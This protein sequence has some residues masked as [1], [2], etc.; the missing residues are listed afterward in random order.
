MWLT[1][2]TLVRAAPVDMELERLKAAASA[3]DARLVVRTSTYDR[4]A[5]E[6]DQTEFRIDTGARQYTMRYKT[7]RDD[8]ARQNAK[9]LNDGSSGYGMVAP[10]QNWYHNGFVQVDLSGPAGSSIRFMEGKP[11][12]LVAAGPRVAYDLVF[13]D[14][15]ATVV[16]RTV[17]LGGRDELFLSVAGRCAI[18]GEG[19]LTTTFCGYPL[20]FAPP[21]D[22]WVHADGQDIRHAD[23]ER[24]QSP[25]D[26]KAAPWLLLAD[27]RLDPSGSKQGLLG[28]A[29]DK[30]VLTHAAVVH[31]RNY[32]ILPSF[33]GS[34]T[35]EQR[36][37]VYTFGPLTWEA[38]RAGLSQ[39]GYPTDLVER[40]FG[41][42]P[43][44]FGE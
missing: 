29:Y 3:A 38:A 22:R 10:H 27:H 13:T 34:A 42:L 33:T 32:A 20:G 36:Y 43:P 7:F 40:A 28:L 25:L 11:R 2:A 4:G 41:G 15:T 6:V 31:N 8:E 26:L 37:I 39:T 12:P 44:P 35:E 23:K 17:A 30:G 16:L 1:A 19:R 24:K 14:Q 5:R 18:D 21:F 9:D